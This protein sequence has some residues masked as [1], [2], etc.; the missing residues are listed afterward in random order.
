MF[1]GSRAVPAEGCGDEGS[2]TD[3]SAMNGWRLRTQF[4]GLVVHA[5]CDAADVLL[6]LARVMGDEPQLA[7]ACGLNSEGG[8]GAAAVAPVEFCEW[9]AIGVLTGRSGH[10]VPPSATRVR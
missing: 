1:V 10:R 4:A 8:L 9:L 6:V 7:G 2:G 3:G 5:D